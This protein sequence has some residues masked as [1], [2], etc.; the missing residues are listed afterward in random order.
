MLRREEKRL[1]R[2]VVERLDERGFELR[3][4]ELDALRERL[5]HLSDR[6]QRALRARGA[7]HVHGIRER[8]Q[9]A[10]LLHEVEQLAAVRQP[11]GQVRQTR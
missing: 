2:D 9:V 6:R 5:V 11:V 10:V 3:E 1:P 8:H 4:R 7:A